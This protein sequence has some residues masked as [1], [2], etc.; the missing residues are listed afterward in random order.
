MRT[1]DWNRQLYKIDNGLQSPSQLV[2][3]HPGQPSNVDTVNSVSMAFATSSKWNL[4]FFFHSRSFNTG[5]LTSPSSNNRYVPLF[6]R[7]VK[8]NQLARASPIVTCKSHL[9]SCENFWNVRNCSRHWILM[10]FLKY[11][12]QKCLPAF[13]L[14]HFGSIGAH[15]K[16]SL[17]WRARR[18]ERK[19]MNQSTV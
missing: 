5:L 14:S 7:N 8:E 9:D 1:I 6:G 10:T 13:L 4:L 2:D 12:I 3:T 16:L 11:I 17:D 18:S 19:W 15:V